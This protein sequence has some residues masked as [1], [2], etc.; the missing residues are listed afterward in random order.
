[1]ARDLRLK[2]VIT[3]SNGR[4]KASLQKSNQ[5]LRRFGANAQNAGKKASTGFHKTRTALERINGTLLSTRRLVLEAFAVRAVIHW[6]AAAVHAFADAEIAM[7]RIHYSLQSAFG[8]AREANQEFGF[9]SNISKELGL[10]L[11]ESAQGYARLAASAQMAGVSLKGL[12]G[13]YRGL[14][15]AATVLHMSG[16]DFNGI[17]VQL[18]QGLSLGR[19]QMRDLRSVAQHIPGAFDMASQAARRMGGSLQAML[20]SG[21]LPAK[22]FFVEFGKVLH[23][24]FGPEATE[25]ATSLN[26]QLNRLH[27]T[28]FE[29][30]LDANKEGFL[31]GF[32][33]AIKRLADMLR[34][35]AVI[36]GIGQFANLLSQVLVLA[37][38][39]GG[40][41][42]KGIE[43]FENALGGAPVKSDILKSLNESIGTKS[44]LGERLEAEQKKLAILEEQAARIHQGA[45]IQGLKNIFTGGIFGIGPEQERYEKLQQ[46]I[47]LRKTAIQNLARAIG[48]FGSGKTVAQAMAENTAKR[49]G[50]ETVNLKKIN[51][52]LEKWEKESQKAQAELDKRAAQRP[53][54]TAKV[55]VSASRAALTRIKATLAARKSA[56]KR[57]LEHNELSYRNYYQ[58]LATMQKKMLEAQLRERRAQ[59]AVIAAEAKVKDQSGA[60]SDALKI[61]AKRK[62]LQAQIN[63]LLAKEGRLGTQTTHQIAD[64]N[65]KLAEKMDG[66]R[67]KLL[68]ITDPLAAAK[69]KI[70]SQYAALIARLKTEG[71][72]SDVA[73]VVKLKTKLEEQATTKAIKGKGQKVLDRYRA[74]QQSLAARVQVGA[75]SQNSAQ[76]KLEALAQSG[77]KRIDQMIVAAK[78]MQGAGSQAVTA[79][80]GMRAQL[81]QMAD[82]LAQLKQKIKS[83]LTDAITNFFDAIFTG[84]KSAKDAFM[85]MARAMLKMIA[86][87]MARKI[88][89][90]IVSSLGYAGGGEVPG[91]AA[92]G[93]I[94]GP[95][96]DTSDN[97]PAMLSPGEF[98]VRAKAVRQV[99]VDTLKAINSGQLANAGRAWLETM[100][101]G[102]LPHRYAA[103]G[104]VSRS[105]HAGDSHAR[106]V[107]THGGVSVSA[108]ISVHV[109]AGENESAQ[110]S[111]RRGR[112][113]GRSLKAAVK[114][115]IANEQRP[116]GLLCGDGAA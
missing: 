42:A 34:N 10:N 97:I 100:R 55:E 81:E 72:A 3:A 47:A 58:R 114:Q 9:L 78:R 18:D 35:P 52:M 29:L 93:K 59:L 74:A 95:G 50:S 115:Q 64:A 48:Q 41:A 87:I 66:V 108:P 26:A 25:A 104:L 12:H 71:R 61:A 99:G 28:I 83:G 113:L 110:E 32:T 116:G 51:A 84:T 24:H 82:P 106:P 27:N 103:G 75:L 44:T 105:R 94:S 8:S 19:L 79:L 69:A 16:E 21:G 2:L 6:G 37:T 56:L 60:G 57:S 15:E 43:R 68:G 112:A 53:V 31:S 23:D 65:A 14:A 96:S 45:G 30:E 111:A 92:G 46:A 89:V 70:E 85:D 17:L 20:A 49:E 76:V 90:K 1:M 73:I 33:E 54:R 86:K 13:A 40:G 67:Q 102:A 101:G 107:Q 4:L 98:V 80:K 109:E 11:R 5:A 63:A 91:K 7:Q 39:L 62:N 38:K 77:L 22:K 88:A 36:S